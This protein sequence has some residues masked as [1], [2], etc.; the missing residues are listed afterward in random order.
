MPGGKT[1]Y[2]AADIALLDTRNISDKIYEILTDRIL[3]GE[4][5]YGQVINIKEIATSLNVSTMPVREAIKRLFYENIVAI[6]PRSN[7]IIKVPTKKSIL[8]S[9]EMREILEMN[10]ISKAYADV[11]ESE[12]STL[13][14]IV[15]TM[16][17]KISGKNGDAKLLEYI[18]LDRLFHEE[19]CHI[20]KNEYIDK[21]YREVNLH[22]TMTYTYGIG[23][24]PDMRQTFTDHRRMKELLSRNSY[25]AVEILQN[26]LNR[27]RQNII[28]GQVFRS[29]E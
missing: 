5:K 19:I 14:Q 15:D 22:L 25:E 4:I 12:L 26:H 9:F 3:S 8:D 24:P 2:M 16:Q 13:Q 7:C 27:S 11:N 29:L 1:A 21:F 6:K 10:S 18:K 23:I 17:D 20:A 28:N